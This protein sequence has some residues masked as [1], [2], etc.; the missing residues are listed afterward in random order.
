LRDAEA[1]LGQQEGHR[2]G[3][4]REQG[5]YIARSRQAASRRLYG[6]VSGL[7]VAL[8][9]AIA[10]AVFAL[11]QRHTAIK[12]TH[13]AQSELVATKATASDDLQYAGL[14]AI[15]AYRLSPTFDA[16]S[17]ILTAAA[18]GKLGAPLAGHVDAVDSVA[19]SPDGRTV[20]SASADR[21]I[22]LWDVASHRQLG[23]PLTGHTRPV[24]SVALSPHGRTLASGGE[25]DT[26]PRIES[27]AAC[28]SCFCASPNQY[29]VQP[30]RQ[31]AR[32]G[33][34]RWLATSPDRQVLRRGEVHGPDHR[35]TLTAR[36]KLASAYWLA[37]HSSDAIT[38]QEWT[39]TV[40][41]S[42]ISLPPIASGHLGSVIPPP[43]AVPRPGCPH[44]PAPTDR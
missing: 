28:F 14:L 23:A 17:A 10:L 24:D 38:L 6:L 27:A 22:R 44:R 32:I 37:E 25:D 39:V 34:W 35:R 21:T 31:Q 43:A 36:S 42:I 30:R 41:P 8:S 1:W 3:P 26:I 19:F 9:I 13:V 11:I 29:R 33:R 18:L 5:E 12:Q 20:A 40:S 7:T 4:T 15:E 2:Q 16:R